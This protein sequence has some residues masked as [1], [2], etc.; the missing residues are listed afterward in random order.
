MT[1]VVSEN[2]QALCSSEDK[3]FIQAFASA[4]ELKN[5]IRKRIVSRRE[6]DWDLYNIST[7]GPFIVLVFKQRQ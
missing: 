4:C 7:Q 6:V 5:E 3:I 2:G 1:N